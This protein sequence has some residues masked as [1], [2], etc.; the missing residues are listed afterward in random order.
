VARASVLRFSGIYIIFKPQVTSIVQLF[1]PV[2]E[3]PMDLKSLKRRPSRQT[4]ILEAPY[5]LPY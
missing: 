5:F 2:R 3:A 4:D 1:P